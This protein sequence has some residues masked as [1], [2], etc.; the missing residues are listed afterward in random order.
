MGAKRNYYIDC[1]V[2]FSEEEKAV[3]AARGLAKH[4]L[5]VDPA[6]PPPAPVH[7][8]SASLLRGFA[9]L[10]LLSSCVLGLAVGDSRRLR[11]STVRR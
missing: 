10:V 11:S 4:T 8:L 7:Y 3:I 9:P 6:V 5:I 2:L 1:E